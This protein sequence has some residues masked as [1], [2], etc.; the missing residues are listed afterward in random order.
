M[1]SVD[2]DLCTGT[3]A[4]MQPFPTHPFSWKLTFT[5]L[6]ND[7]KLYLCAPKGLTNVKLNGILC[8]REDS[9]FPAE[10]NALK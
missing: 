2:K 3:R 4:L 6:G 8:L 1:E 9:A 7:A 5:L 10:L